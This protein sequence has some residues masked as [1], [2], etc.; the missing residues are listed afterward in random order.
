M[1][2]AW[3]ACNA[4]LLDGLAVAV[5]LFEQLQIGLDV[6]VGRVFGAGFFELLVGAGIVAAQ[7]V[8][9]ALV[10]EDFGRRAD[11]AQRRSIG[12]VGEIETVQPVIRRGEPDPGAGIVRML[13]H[14]AA[15]ALLG[16]TEIVAAEILLAALRVVV[17]IV[18][19]EA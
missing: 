11:E 19:D 9:E 1:F 6:G 14:G 8:G 3:A 7:H 4:A 16:E 5:A 15:E 10:V 13:F 17:W 12:A 18:T 2:K